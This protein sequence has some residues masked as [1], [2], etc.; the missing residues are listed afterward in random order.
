LSNKSNVLLNKS[1]EIC[2]N[3]LRFN[4]SLMFLEVNFKLI[5]IVKI[6]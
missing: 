3:L 4:K 1:D 2:N 6:E 5:P